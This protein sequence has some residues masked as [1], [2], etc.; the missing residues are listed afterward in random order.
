VLNVMRTNGYQT[1]LE[2]EISSASAVRLVQMLYAAALDS[3][4]SARRFLRAG[5]IRARSRAITKAMRIVTEL[6]RSL[7]REAGAD[8]SQN[9]ANL[10][11]YVLKLLMESNSKQ[12]EPPL[13]E[14]EVLMTTLAE[15]WNRAV[16]PQYETARL[17]NS[18]QEPSVGYAPNSPP[19][20]NSQ[21][22]W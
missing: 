21:P 3:I 22:A 19:S 12:I 4:A 17:E 14:A 13:A 20:Q 7:N 2:N 16:I 10:Y 9:L 8:L 11:G 5:E 15:A 1:Y 6:S 18:S